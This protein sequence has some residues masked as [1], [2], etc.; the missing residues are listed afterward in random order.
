MKI[1]TSTF[2]V[3]DTPG[4]GDEKGIRL[5]ADAGFEALDFGLFYWSKDPRFQMSD[6]AHEA[7]YRRLRA[8]CDDCGIE[9]CQAHSPMP[10]YVYTGDESVDNVYM[11][12]QIRA[13]KSAA[14]LGAK[15]IVVHPVILKEDRRTPDRGEPLREKCR[16]I[17]YKYYSK[18]KP[19]CEE[20]GIRIAVENMFNYDPDAGKIC[21]TVCS[22]PAEMKEYVDM[23]GRE[24]FTNCLDIGHNVLVD[25][26]PQ[27]SIRELG[28]YLGCLH[29][30]DNDGVRD[31]HQAPYTGVVEWPEVMQALQ[32][33][34]YAGTFNMEADMFF[35]GYGKRLYPASAK[36]LY[37]I[38]RDLVGRM[39]IE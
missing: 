20:Y 28:D 11:R 27:D 38:G 36:F 18:L 32:E 22:T 15:Y 30:H 33:I 25:L 1:S 19:Y 10:D 8:V 5:L 14:L 17:N 16:E 23:M 34:G 7:Y 26:K 31:L 4:I 9:V 21:R 13:M 3:L 24:W 37:Q 2:T 12:M 29:V 39:E 6:E 35:Y